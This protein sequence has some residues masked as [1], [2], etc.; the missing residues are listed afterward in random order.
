MQRSRA[1][2]GLAGGGALDFGDIRYALL[3]FVDLLGL[4]RGRTIPADE[5]DAALREGIGF[6][7]S[8]IPGFVDIEDS[9]MVMKPDPTTFT[10][11]PEYFYNR[12]VALF[13]CDIYRPGGLRF[14]GDSRYVC[15]KSVEKLREQGL[16]PTVAAEL[17]FYLV[18]WNGDGTLG[19]VEDFVS[20]DHRYFDIDPARDVS[21]T[22]RMDL[23]DALTYMGIK[24]ERHHHEVGPAQSEITFGYA[25]PVR[26]SD[27]I[28]RYKVAARLVA[29]RK[30]G[31]TVT[32][33]PK[34]WFGRAGNG[35]HIHVGLRR[36]DENLFFDPDGY[37]GI[38]QECRYFIGGILYHARALSAIVAPT[39]N[40]YKRL[41]PGYEAPVYITW[42]RRNRSALIRIPEYYPGLKREARI[43]FRCPDP[44]CNPYLTYAAVYEAG[45]DGIRRK[46][47]P[48]DPVEENVYEL[49]EARR[50]ELG[51]GVLP[52]SLKEALEE[53]ESDDICIRAIGRENAQK[54]LELKMAEWR[55]Y[56]KHAPEEPAQVTAWE[57]RKYL[58]A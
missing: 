4:L 28:I 1:A 58:Y 8:N 21:E 24:V 20:S 5:L 36:G 52:S 33:M 23:C 40:S 22:Y 57:I 56:E 53:W 35:M 6:D 50:R 41:V 18:R 13:L 34:P 27:D 38:S 30:Y 46:I 3:Y 2:A 51:V 12:P 45:M 29:Q 55:E 31:W 15:Q 44:L 26:L 37:A 43:E 19:S 10:P 16:E 48:G 49:S 42:S 7:G 54:Y 39:V 17:E 25:D 14:N 32:F 47:D 9:D 11:L